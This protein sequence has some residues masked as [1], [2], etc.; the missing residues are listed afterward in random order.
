MK[1]LRPVPTCDRGPALAL[2]CPAEAPCSPEKVPRAWA[3]RTD[4][5]VL[6]V[7]SG[8]ALALAVAAGPVL[9]A[10]RV[11]GPLVTGRSRPAVLAAARAPHAGTVTATVR[12][13]DLCGEWGEW[14]G[15]RGQGGAGVGGEREKTS[16]E[17]VVVGNKGHTWLPSSA[18]VSNRIPEA[19]EANLCGQ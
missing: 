17:Q 9:G 18:F 5:A 3:L 19:R 14:R 7:P 10:A 6:A 13:T 15:K 4:G 16:V 11:A 1:G 12:S 2:K 8:A